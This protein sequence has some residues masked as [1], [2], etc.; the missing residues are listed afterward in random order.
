MSWWSNRRRDLISAERASGTILE[1]GINA[2]HM[3][4]VVAFGQPP[5]PLPVFCFV[6]THTTIIRPML[7]LVIMKP[8]KHR[9]PYKHCTKA[10]SEEDDGEG[11]DQGDEGFVAVAATQP[12]AQ[13]LANYFHVI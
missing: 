8:G 12:T 3:E 4:A 7:V 6:K 2:I 11:D 13:Y 9:K 10:D 1:P 5:H